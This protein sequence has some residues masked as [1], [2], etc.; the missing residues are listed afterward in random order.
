MVLRTRIALATFATFAVLPPVTGAESK[1]PMFYEAEVGARVLV[2]GKP[3]QRQIYLFHFY[4][5]E[6]F[7]DS[8]KKA[9]CSLT[10]VVLNNVNCGNDRSPYGGD[11]TG[12]FWVE[13]HF[14]DNEDETSGVSCQLTALPDAKRSLTITQLHTGLLADGT[15]SHHFIVAGNGYSTRVLDYAGQR[16]QTL[17]ISHTLETDVYSPIRALPGTDGTKLPISCSRVTVPSISN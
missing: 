2:N 15:V 1:Y 6:P 7:K 8:G 17:A 16:S 9:Y 13:T 10:T 3:D 5:A 4:Y 11:A 12:A 14:D